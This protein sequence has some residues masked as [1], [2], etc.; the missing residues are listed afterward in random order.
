[1]AIDIRYVTSSII[2]TI[3]LI[4]SSNMSLYGSCMGLA[5]YVFDKI[6]IF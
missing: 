2:P 5:D 1:M 6:D 3:Q 4:H